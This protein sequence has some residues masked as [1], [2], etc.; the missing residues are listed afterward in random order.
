MYN[1]NSKLVSGQ[2]S[3]SYRLSTS[4]SIPDGEILFLICFSLISHQ[5]LQI[6]REY[7]S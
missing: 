2:L 4:G 5:S 6:C 7:A 3:S 1:T